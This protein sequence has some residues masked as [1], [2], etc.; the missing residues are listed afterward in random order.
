MTSPSPI[1][2]G[3]ASI[4][5]VDDDQDLLQLNAQALS[6]YFEVTTATSTQEASGLMREKVFKVIVCDYTMPGGDGLS[7][8]VKTSEKYP[9]TQR[10]LI[11]GYLKPGLLEN[12]NAT[13]LYRYLLKPVSL[14]ELIKTVQKAAKLHDQIVT[15]KD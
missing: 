13:A 2:P 3:P 11:T 8:L 9:H 12:L 7:F 6:P 4:L 5:L 14:P 10:V 15:T 1:P